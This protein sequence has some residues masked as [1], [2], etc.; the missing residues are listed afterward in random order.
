MRADPIF[1]QNLEETRKQLDNLS[2]NTVAMMQD[3]EGFVQEQANRSN[4]TNQ[5]ALGE[6]FECFDKNQV[7]HS[8][9]P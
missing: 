1:K 3:P 2:E 8:A 7:T 4:E 6:I 9:A 5:K